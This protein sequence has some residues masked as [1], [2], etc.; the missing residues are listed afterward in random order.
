MWFVQRV[1]LVREAWHITGLNCF[2]KLCSKI[3]IER[4]RGQIQSRDRGR[5]DGEGNFVRGHG[6]GISD[7]TM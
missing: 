1:P 5:K 6:P 2:G 7:G 4:G 3:E